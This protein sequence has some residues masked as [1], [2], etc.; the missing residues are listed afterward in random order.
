MRK[1][2]V[3][4][5]CGENRARS[6]MAEAFLRILGGEQYEVQSAGL[7]QSEIHPYTLKVM[8]EIDYDLSKHHSK[9]LSKF[10]GKIHFNYIIT[11]CDRAKEK[12]PTF[13]S[14][15][16]QLNWAVEDPVAFEG[17]DEDKLEKF[18]EVRNNLKEKIVEWLKQRGH[19]TD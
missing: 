18:R 11:V 16:I 8:E 12:C 7:E 19:Y 15:T 14:G 4:F 10:R 1:I 3:I 6:Q 9:D 13:P 5:I 17:S 2:K